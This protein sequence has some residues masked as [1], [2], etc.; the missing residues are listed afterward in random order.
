MDLGFPV[1]AETLPPVVQAAPAAAPPEW[2]QLAD[3]DKYAEARKSLDA[4]GGFAAVLP[5]ASPTQLMTLTD[6]ARKTGSREIAILALRRV[7]EGFPQAAVAPE[8]ALTLGNL[9]EQAGD[10]AGAREAY[11]LYRR[12]SPGGDFAEDAL[13]RQVDSALAQGNLE[14]LMRLFAQYENDFPNGPRLEEFRAELQKRSVPAPT[15][16]PSGTVGSPSGP[17]KDAAPEAPK[18]PSK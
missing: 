9:L 13:A 11:A 1:P 8:A 12:L 5:S 18:T 15:G 6:I 7:V 2:E 4:H 14:E 3:D 10:G 17:E 16:E